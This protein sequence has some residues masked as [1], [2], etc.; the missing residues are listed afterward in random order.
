MV[1]NKPEGLTRLTTYLLSQTA[2]VAKLDLDERLASEGFRLRHMAV[3]AVLDEAPA[4]QLD[5]GRRLAMDPSDVTATIDDLEADDLVVRSMDPVDR[6]RKIVTATPRGLR[7]LQWMQQVAQDLCDELLQ[8]VPPHRRAQLHQDLH[9]VL[10]ARD[11]R[12][13]ERRTARS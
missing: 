6:R 12:E 8:P 13:A 7:K 5:L 2:K 1:T 3:L 11:A 9:R 4:T 10:L